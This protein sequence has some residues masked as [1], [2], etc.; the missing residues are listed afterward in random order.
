MHFLQV[1]IDAITEKQTSE[2]H[3]LQVN[4]I[5]REIITKNTCID[6]TRA[7]LKATTYASLTIIVNLNRIFLTKRYF[8]LEDKYINTSVN[9]K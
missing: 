8:R 1:K 9:G 7:I 6:V 2:K 3:T 5:K 4:N